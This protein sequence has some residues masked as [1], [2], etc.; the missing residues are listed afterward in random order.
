[1]F[2]K[3]QNLTY[4][5]MFAIPALWRLKQGDHCK[6]EDRLGYKRGPG[7]HR[8][9]SNTLLQKNKIKSS[10]HKCPVVIFTDF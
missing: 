10:K 1:M 9:Q 2:K 6:T 7:H 8:P 5:V 3:A 4:R